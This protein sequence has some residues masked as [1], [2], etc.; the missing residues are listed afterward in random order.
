MRRFIP[1][2]MAAFYLALALLMAAAGGLRSLAGVAEAGPEI[3]GDPSG[4]SLRAL[5]APASGAD[6]ERI[7]YFDDDAYTMADTTPVASDPQ[8]GLGGYTIFETEV[9]LVGTMTGT[10]P[11]LTVL[12]QDSIDGG[13][14]WTNIGTW[15]QINATVTPAVQNQTVSDQVGSTAVAYGDCMRAVMT[16]GGTGT[17]TANVGIKGQAK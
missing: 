3:V 10:N 2:K 4:A 14:T 1:S 8:C 5:V 12:W 13:E 6:A 16:F 17:V 11:T 15:T 7:V 9:R